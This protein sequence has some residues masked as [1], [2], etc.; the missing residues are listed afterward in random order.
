MTKKQ[1][2]TLIELVVVIL[3]AVLVTVSASSVM[4]LGLRIHRASVEDMQRNI[5]QK[6]N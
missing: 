4:L 5:S 1:G 2:F 6:Q 3:C